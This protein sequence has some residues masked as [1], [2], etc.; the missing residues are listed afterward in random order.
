MNTYNELSTAVTSFAGQDGNPD[1]TNMVGVFIDLGEADI[2]RLLR[3]DRMVKHY[4]LGG[5]APYEVPDDF[6]EAAAVNQGYAVCE[7]APPDLLLSI[8]ASTDVPTHWSIFGN[9][10]IFNG[11]PTV[12]TVISYFARPTSLATEAN[13]LFKLNPDLFL[14]AALSHAM[15]FLRDEAR[16]AVWTGLFRAKLAEINAASWDARVPRQQPLRTRIA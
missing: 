11:T 6:L 16:Q 9:E 12:E 5:A 15:I 10:F 1:F 14:Y 8:E 4:T 7:Y 2:Y 13:A 3:H